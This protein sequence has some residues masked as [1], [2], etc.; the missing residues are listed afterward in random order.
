MKVPRDQLAE[1]IAKL[2]LEQKNPKRLAKAVAAYLLSEHRLPELESLLRDIMQYRL[3][4]GVAEAEAVSV[5]PLPEAVERDIK[6]LL[7]NAYPM[8]KRVTVNQRQDESVI[9]GVQIKL[10]NQQFD[11]SVRGRLSKFKRLIEAKG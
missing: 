2:T 8:V 4:H 6:A 9:G 11:D 7:K 3:D 1:A 10:A 5:R